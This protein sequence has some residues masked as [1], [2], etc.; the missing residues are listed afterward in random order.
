MLW[1]LAGDA[2]ASVSAGLV[3]QAGTRNLW[4]EAVTA[5][6]RWLRYGHSTRWRFGLTMT[7]EHQWVW[8]DEPTN[9]VHV[10]A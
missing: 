10:L 6:Q 5:H 4:D 3:L 9:M 7:R 2:W 1:L 8:L